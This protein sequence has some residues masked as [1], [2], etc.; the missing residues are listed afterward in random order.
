MNL[1]QSQ[2][3]NIIHQDNVHLVE[4]IAQLYFK[5][6]II[7]G[8]PQA[9]PTELMKHAWIRIAGVIDKCNRIFAGKE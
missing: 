9:A 5:L 1:K 7:E 6:W 4:S 2:Q 8:K 3:F